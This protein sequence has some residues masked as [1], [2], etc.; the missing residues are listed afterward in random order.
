LGVFSGQKKINLL[1]V[2][3][4]FALFF[5]SGAD[6]LWIKV[7]RPCQDAFAFFAM[8]R[9]KESLAVPEV[10]FAFELP[11]LVNDAAT[12]DC[13]NVARRARVNRIGW[14]CVCLILRQQPTNTA[15]SV[16]RMSKPIARQVV[17]L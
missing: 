9:V 14:Q 13:L 5:S 7:R 2:V 17:R 16:N 15:R 4:V 10:A 1:V 12:A 11:S 8:G 6:A 3:S